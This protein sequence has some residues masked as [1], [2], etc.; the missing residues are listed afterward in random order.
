MSSCISPSLNNSYSLFHIHPRVLNPLHRQPIPE[1]F[2]Y[3]PA[4]F[5]RLP[6]QPAEVVS[7]L[8]PTVTNPLLA[9]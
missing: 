7:C 1:P 3:P 9:L 6:S 4:T 8:R 5:I 2:S